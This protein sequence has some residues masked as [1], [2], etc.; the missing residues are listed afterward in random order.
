MSSTHIPTRTIAVVDADED[1]LRPE[2]DAG[3]SSWP[4]FAY[5]TLPRGDSFRLLELLP[6]PDSDS[7]R[8]RLVAFRLDA[9]N[10]PPYRALSYTWGASQYDRLFVDGQRVPVESSLHA[11]FAIRHPLYVQ[12]HRL[13]ISTNLRDALRCIRHRH[14]PV[15][16]WVDAVCINQLDDAER[17]AQIM[18]MPRIYH[19]ASSVILWIFEPVS[20][21][22]LATRLSSATASSNAFCSRLRPTSSMIFCWSGVSLFHVFMLIAMGSIVK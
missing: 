6:G 22:S 12:D 8:C 18:L 7:L 20:A 14:V 2:A 21:N 5:T 15:K 17:S 1:P 13:L 3:A 10:V 4:P 9:F 16:L 11:R 19:H